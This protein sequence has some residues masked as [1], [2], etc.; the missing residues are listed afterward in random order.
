M[1]MSVFIAFFEIILLAVYIWSFV[2]CRKPK[3]IQVFKYF[4]DIIESLI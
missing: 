2:V 3:N 1:D 4:I